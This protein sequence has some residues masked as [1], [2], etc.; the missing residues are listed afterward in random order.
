MLGGGLAEADALPALAQRHRAS[1]HSCSSRGENDA[2]SAAVI[3][4]DLAAVAGGIRVS[5]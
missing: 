2:F 5:K 1:G 3:K 4:K